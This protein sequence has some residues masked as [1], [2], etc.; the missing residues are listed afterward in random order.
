ML[1]WGRGILEDVG[2]T[3]EAGEVQEV[4][5]TLDGKCSGSENL[6]GCRGIFQ[7]LG[8][9]SGGSPAV[10]RDPEEVRR[11]WGGG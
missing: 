6:L 4:V 9:S 3:L 11:D 5:E 10:P 1:L 7:G 2:E 8:G